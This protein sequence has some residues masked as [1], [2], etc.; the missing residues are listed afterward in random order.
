MISLPD[1]STQVEGDTT[2]SSALRKFVR[3]N[4]HSGIER[5]HEEVDFGR[6][7]GKDSDLRSS[8]H[9]QIKAS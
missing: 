5:K 3:D 8:L 2:D 7:E 9:Q 6:V 4:S 1:T